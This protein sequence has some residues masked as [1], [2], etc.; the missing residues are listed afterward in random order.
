MKGVGGSVPRRLSPIS[1][2]QQQDKPRVVNQS[3]AN[4]RITAMIDMH[5]KDIQEADNELISTKIGNTREDEYTSV[6]LRQTRI[7]DTNDNSSLRIDDT[8]TLN[9]NEGL[10]NIIPGL[11]ISQLNNNRYK[12]FNHNEDMTVD[13]TYKVDRSVFAFK[14]SKTP[15]PGCRGTSDYAGGFLLDSKRTVTAQDTS[16][17]RSSY[18]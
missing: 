1:L 11:K 2:S 6:D 18:R 17:Y 9:A 7:N 10:P 12:K 16:E 13:D 3:E 5:S 15:L 8:V 14:P 4:S